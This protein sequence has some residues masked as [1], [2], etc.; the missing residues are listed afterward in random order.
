M[1]KQYDSY[2]CYEANFRAIRP[3]LRNLIFKIDKRELCGEVNGLRGGF[4]VR[5]CGWAKKGQIKFVL[6]LIM[7]GLFEIST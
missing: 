1:G 5:K 7:L 4:L 3:K 6:T 2:A